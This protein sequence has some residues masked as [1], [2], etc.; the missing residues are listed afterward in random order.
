MPAE[1]E[2]LAQFIAANPAAVGTQRRRV[3]V[4]NAAHRR[5]GHRPPGLAEV[6]REHI[7]ASRAARRRQLTAIAADVVEHLPTEGWPV[8]LF[9]LRDSLLLVL[10]TSGIRSAALAR[11]RVGD[12]FVDDHADQLHI[13]ADGAGDFA[14]DPALVDL[15]ISPMA[16]LE[17]WLPLRAL[18]HHVPSP[19]VTASAL[20][21]DPTPRVPAAPDDAPLFVP[22]DGWGVPPL[23]TSVHLS[24]PIV[25]SVLRAH[26][27]GGAP[28]HRRVAQRPAPSSSPAPDVVEEPSPA[29]LDPE[30][31]ERGLAARRAAKSALADVDDVLDAVEAEA[32]RRLE[33]LLRILEEENARG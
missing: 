27:T 9:A 1:P 12:V 10:A 15:G 22:L 7:D 24:G 3:A 13:A 25:A 16:V 4:I 30:S 26:L 19:S 18:Q 31:W 8:E 20:R 11:L 2:Q 5:A 32:S 23:D 33:D 28:P 29:P 6:V 14:T 17:Q 21:G